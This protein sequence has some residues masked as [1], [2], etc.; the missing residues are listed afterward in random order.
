MR[1]RFAAA[2]ALL[3]GSALPA[4]AGSATQSEDPRVTI[5]KYQMML[6]A[7]EFA[8]N[9]AAETIGKLRDQL[10]S[11]QMARQ[12]AETDAKAAKEALAK[13]QHKEPAKPAMSL[14][15]PQK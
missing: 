13:A 8:L 5:A 2:V 1:L 14:P 15:K 12:K 7:D 4:A 3:I 6:G 10:T 9:Q 11:L